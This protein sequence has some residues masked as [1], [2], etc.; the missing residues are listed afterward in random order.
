MTNK[1]KT[2]TVQDALR[3]IEDPQYLY[4]HID[5]LSILNYVEKVIDESPYITT[6]KDFWRKK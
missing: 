5:R 4:T 1:T 6:S 2:A 3:Y